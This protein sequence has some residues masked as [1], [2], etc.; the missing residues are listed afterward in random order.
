MKRM[1]S[2]SLVV[3]VTSNTT[4]VKFGADWSTFWP[5]SSSWHC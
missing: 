2:N 5:D 1:L 3:G 4:M